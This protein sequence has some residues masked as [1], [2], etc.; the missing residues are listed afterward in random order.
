MYHIYID[1]EGW[2]CLPDGT[3][4]RGQ[5]DAETNQPEGLGIVAYSEQLFYVGELHKGLR[6]GRGFMLR[7][8]VTTK[9]VNQFIHYTYE[10]VMSTAE[11]DCCGR[12]IS[13]GPEGH[14]ETY[15]KKEESFVKEQDGQWSNDQFLTPV[16]NSVLT[17]EPWSQLTL[18]Q[19]K[20]A[21]GGPD[22]GPYRTPLNTITDEGIIK[23]N[24]YEHYVTPY[25]DTRLMILGPFGLLA[26]C[27]L[28][29][30]GSGSYRDQYNTHYAT[31]QLT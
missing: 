19:E 22:Y 30:G 14:V 28:K 27:D 2:L 12:V 31:Y 5:L 7:I 18:V 17:R 13:T 15:E 26:T 16:D 8:V 10:E 24:G 11:F 21:V 23:L 9:T 29:D 4:Y 3:C 20:G 6:H 1:K 25:D